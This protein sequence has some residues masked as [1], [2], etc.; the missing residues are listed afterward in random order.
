MRFG[1]GLF[2][3]GDQ[4]LSLGD[5]LQESATRVEVLLVLLQM[6]GKPFD[7]LGEEGD[8]VF[9]RPR[10]LLMPFHFLR[11]PILLLVRQRHSIIQPYLRIFLKR[12]TRVRY[13][14]ILLIH[15]ITALFF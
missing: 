7:L 12:D 14:K 5:H 2:E 13:K 9:R 1:I 11:Y 10:I 15:H 4:L 6:E 8:L 3:V